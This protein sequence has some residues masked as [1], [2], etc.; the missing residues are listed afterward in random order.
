MGNAG[1]KE[2]PVMK[3]A[4][5]LFLGVTLTLLA[6]SSD[7]DGDAALFAVDTDNSGAVDCEDLHHVQVCLEHPDST[8]CAHA[9]VNGDGVVD[10][11]DVHDIYDGLH[12]TGHDCEAPDGHDDGTGDHADAG[13]HDGTT[14]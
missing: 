10:E 14:H 2:P 4:A 12:E 6:C 8:D 9:D 11:N 13:S 1:Q 3:A 7:Q 5:V